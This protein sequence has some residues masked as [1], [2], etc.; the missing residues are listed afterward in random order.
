MPYKDPE[1][2]KEANRKWRENNPEYMKEYYQNNKEKARQKSKAWKKNNPEKDKESRRKS[3]KKYYQ[4]NPE[5]VNEYRRDTKLQAI[6]I[7]GS[8][9]QFQAQ[10]ITIGGVEHHFKSCDQSWQ[11][12]T[13]PDFLEF[14]HINGNTR[15]E[16]THDVRRR[17][18]EYGYQNDLELLCFNHHK[19]A[20]IRD[21]TTY[22]GSKEEISEPM[23][24]VKKLF[25]ILPR[26]T[27][28]MEDG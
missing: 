13:L 19:L 26:A 10:T 15:K 14:H 3:S 27:Q 28:I 1:K 12:I 7:Y 25:K 24:N 22:N 23:K 18:V 20:N 5:Y 16:Q 2:Q 17:I 8:K 11:D 9:C 4:E 6:A 21:G